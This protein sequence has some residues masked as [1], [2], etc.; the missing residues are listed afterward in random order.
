MKSALTKS[1]FHYIIYFNRNTENFTQAGTPVIIFLYILK[2]FVNTM[3]V[4]CNTFLLVGIIP[5]MMMKRKYWNLLREKCHEI[6]LKH[7]ISEYY[8]QFGSLHG[9]IKGY[10]VRVDIITGGSS[11]GTYITIKPRSKDMITC[12]SLDK[13]KPITRP[14]PVEKDFRTDNPD[15][16]FIFKT[17]RS[18][19]STGSIILESP[20]LMDLFVRFYV[21]W[22]FRIYRFCVD[23][24][25]G[26]F[27]CS[28][29]YG[30]PFNAYVPP[31]ILKEILNDLIDIIALF[32]EK[33]ITNSH[34]D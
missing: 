5:S 23:I 3:K 7:E 20:E 27:N 25:G 28:L 33:I 26:G 22:I 24:P 16:N 8:D 21:R 12:L 10:E 2:G 1:V 30:L 15:F 18:D 13:A 9:N 11:T 34:H 19:I 4:L 31:D 14:N 32:D 17:F 29:N 6:G